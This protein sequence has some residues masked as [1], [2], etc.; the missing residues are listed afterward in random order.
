MA[1]KPATLTYAEASG[2]GIATVTGVRA[3]I[4]TKVA[5]GQRLLITG[6]AGG[7]G[8]A[9][10]QAAKVRG[11]YVIGTASGTTPRLSQIPWRG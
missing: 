11:A 4:E 3:V 9:A 1:P 5:Q 6:V 10:T 7:V 8:S 2:L